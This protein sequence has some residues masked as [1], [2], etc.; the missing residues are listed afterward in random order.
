MAWFVADLTHHLFVLVFSGLTWRHD[1]VWSSSI[2]LRGM[3]KASSCRI[4]EFEDYS[5][6]GLQLSHHHRFI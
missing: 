4:D 5:L 6:V 3:R 1:F 2:R